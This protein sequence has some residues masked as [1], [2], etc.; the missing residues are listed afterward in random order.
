MRTRLETERK[1]SKK[2]AFKAVQKNV[3]KA[4][5]RSVFEM[6]ERPKLISLRDK[7][8]SLEEKRR[9]NARVKDVTFEN[10]GAVTDMDLTLDDLIYEMD[11]WK[12]KVLVEWMRNAERDRKMVAAVEE[13]ESLALNRKH[14]HE[15]HG[16]VEE[17][18]ST[19]VTLKKHRKSASAIEEVSSCLLHTTECQKV[20]EKRKIAV[21]EE[22]FAFEKERA[23]KTYMKF[24]RTKAVAERRKTLKKRRLT[25]IKRSSR[26]GWKEIILNLEAEGEV[27]YMVAVSFANLIGQ[28]SDHGLQKSLSCALC[29]VEVLWDIKCFYLKVGTHL[30]AF[31]EASPVVQEKFAWFVKETHGRHA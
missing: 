15:E 22:R 11:K 6:Y 4:I 31:V 3:M 18:R 1:E 13:T 21:E 29:T 2:Q 26:N 14:S 8:M 20:M 24:E 16:E 23:E 9:E 7:Y 17:V 19:E 27:R 5:P 12:E 10:L 25:L 30:T 28:R